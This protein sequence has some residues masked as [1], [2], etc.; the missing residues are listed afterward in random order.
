MRK[1]RTSPL[2]YQ[3]FLFEELPDRK[4]IVEEDNPCI[5]VYGRDK[6][7]HRCDGCAHLCLDGN[8][9]RCNLRRMRKEDIHHRYWLACGKYT[10]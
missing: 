3:E 9:W 7:G 6:D 10:A 2:A 1:R 5:A 8:V 4:G